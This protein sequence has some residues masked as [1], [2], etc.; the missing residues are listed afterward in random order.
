MR[1]RRPRGNG[2]GIDLGRSAQVTQWPLALGILFILVAFFMPSAN[3]MEFGNRWVVA[4]A[5]S[6]T[7]VGAWIDKNPLASDLNQRYSEL[8]RTSKTSVGILQIRDS[9]IRH[10]NPASDQTLTVLKGRGLF[11]LDGVS[12]PVHT[13]DVIL[14]PA[15]STSAFINKSWRK[16]PA[17]LWVVSAPP[18]TVGE[19]DR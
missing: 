12:Q 11:Y 15:G 1:D 2:A 10:S 17:V 6:G 3:P 13:G 8:T 16:N 5:P 9:E 4:S 19:G 7:K 14:V 18:T